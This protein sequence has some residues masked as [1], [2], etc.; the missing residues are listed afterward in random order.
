MIL[1]SYDIDQNFNFIHIVC[2]RAQ[3]D[4]QGHQ[5]IQDRRGLL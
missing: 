3:A 5:E 2:F 1:E 4:P